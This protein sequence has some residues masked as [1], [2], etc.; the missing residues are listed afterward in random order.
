VV[1]LL[2][3]I[4][5]LAVGYFWAA[6]HCKY[7]NIMHL[8]TQKLVLSTDYHASEIIKIKLDWF[9]L[10][11]DYKPSSTTKYIGYDCVL[12]NSP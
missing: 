1:C 3:A 11:N 5:R 6:R 9:R 2:G 4:H 8:F 10:N 7:Y 12:F